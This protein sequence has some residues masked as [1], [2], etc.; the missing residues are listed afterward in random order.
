[1]YSLREPLPADVVGHASGPFDGYRRYPV[2]SAPWLIGR[3]LIFIPLTGGLGALE[4]LLI[5]LEFNDARLGWQ[6][7]CVAL[8]IWIS[9]GS[10]G[11]V[12][13][14]FARHRLPPAKL[15]TTLAILMGVALSFYLQQVATRFVVTTILPRYM[16][17]LR[18]RAGAIH[19]I[20]TGI[21]GRLK[22]TVKGRTEELPV[23]QAFQFRFKPM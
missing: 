17:V 21:D 19:R 18:V 4:G 12:L 11:P 16:A 22:L 23:S 6:T 2:F 9:I 8:P 10:A 3:C 13:A 14:T 5:G 15:S 7:A 1:M 20:E